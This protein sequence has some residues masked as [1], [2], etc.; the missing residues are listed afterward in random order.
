MSD[1][2]QALDVAG[3]LRQ[4]YGSDRENRSPKAGATVSHHHHHLRLPLLF[5]QKTGLRNGMRPEPTCADGFLA[6]LTAADQPEGF[7]PDRHAA[8]ARLLNR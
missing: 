5:A 3:K 4:S 2:G 6:R 8:P 1:T 7:L